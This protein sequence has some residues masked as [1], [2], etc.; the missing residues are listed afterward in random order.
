MINKKHISLNEGVIEHYQKNKDLK[1]LY[2]LG[3]VC[4]ITSGLGYIGYDALIRSVTDLTGVS[5]RTA[6]AW[7][8]ELRSRAHIRIRKGVVYVKTKRLI[9]N[10]F[11]NGRV[12]I[13][14]E[15]DHLKNYN[16]FRDHII[17]QLALLKQRRFRHAFKTMSVADANSLLISGK[18]ESPLAIIKDWNKVGCSISQIVKNYGFDKKTV[19][20]ALK[21]Y[22]TKQWNQTRAVK[23]TFMRKKYA[24]FLSELRKKHRQV[25]HRYS[26]SYCPGTD[27]YRVLYALGSTIGVDSMLFKR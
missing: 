9:E 22:A 7:I 5:P 3:V 2:C 18:I 17:R 19:S 26:F 10:E 12:F 14:F 4:F 6:R 20:G 16:K 23:G 21:G 13:G 11:G 1:A 27:T 25:S 24:D 8:L 15:K